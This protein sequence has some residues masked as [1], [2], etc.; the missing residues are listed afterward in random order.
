MVTTPQVL[1]SIAMSIDP[2]AS[3]GTNGTVGMQVELLTQHILGRVSIRGVSRGSG[4]PAPNGTVTDAR[5]VR[6]QPRCR[7]VHFS[8]SFLSAF[9]IK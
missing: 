2:A 5:A 1:F 7:V 8:R 6:S 3:A 4:D 9:A